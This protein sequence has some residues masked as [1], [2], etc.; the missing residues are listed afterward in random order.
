MTPRRGRRRHLALAGV[1]GA[2]LCVGLAACSASEG[3]TR[4]GPATHAAGPSAR[5]L[6][7]DAV[8]APKYVALAG[9][10]RQHAVGVWVEADLVAAW[11]KGETAYERAVAIA[12]DLARR[13]GVLGIKVADELGYRDGTDP[14]SALALLHRV[15]TDIRAALPH[16][17]ILID[18]VVPELG[19]LGWAP[20]ATAEQQLCADAA[21]ARDPGAGLAAVDRYVAS[22]DVDVIDLSPGLRDEDWYAAQ[23]TT[24][25]AAMRA[26]WRE[27]VRRWGSRVRLQARKAL[28]HPGSYTLTPAQAEADV[29][30]FVDIPL[31]EGA[32]AVD[33][34]TWAQRYHGEVVRL[35]DP[36]GVDNA[37]TRALEERRRQGAQLWTHMSPSTLQADLDHD[38]AAAARLFDVVFVAAGTG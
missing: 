15:H 35:T 23:G 18:V 6:Q 11:Q 34:W 16:A 28:A 19:C 13:P 5:S 7:E 30:T 26:V 31:S 4:S 29:H 38:V 24:R 3:A 8:A 27:A 20:G 32:R 21:R 14:T 1:L 10:L 12:V 9:L 17:G 22:G 37:L 2:L 36:G 25:D 33:I